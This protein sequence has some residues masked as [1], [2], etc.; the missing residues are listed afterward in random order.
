[1]PKR[2]QGR[3]RRRS[4]KRAKG[5]SYRETREVKFID[6][7]TA[8]GFAPASLSGTI[9]ADTIVG[10]LGG[11]LQNQ[12]I[13]R[14]V[15]V[16]GIGMSIFIS[17]DETVNAIKTTDQMRIVCYQD[18]QSNGNAA[19]PIE[20]YRNQLGPITTIVSY[21]NL[22]FVERFRILSDKTYSLQSAASDAG[23]YA[24]DS[25]IDRIWIPANIPVIYSGTGMDILDVQTN[26]IGI[27]VY[28]SNVAATMTIQT[29]V[30]YTDM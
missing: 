2:R 28:S 9:W 8:N 27:I 3:K 29:R 11:T 14:K 10:I 5:P 24:R 25:L 21:R 15:H 7:T 4:F 1:M 23:T 20:L 22:E 6:N 18:K 17:L 13:G 16:T 12:R 26:N 19:V 30:R